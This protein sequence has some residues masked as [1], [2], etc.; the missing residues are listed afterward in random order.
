MAVGEVSGE[1]PS[2][3]AAKGADGADTEDESPASTAYREVPVEVMRAWYQD[4]QELSSIRAICQEAGIGRTTLHN[5]I[6]D[7]TNPHPRVRR[8]LAIH[9]LKTTGAGD[10][11]VAIARDAL[12]KLLPGIPEHQAVGE[13]AGIYARYGVDTRPGGLHS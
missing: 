8:L 12:P 6:C 13:L 7:G 5:V 4:Q 11:A 9:Y 3:D 1:T 2:P 10:P